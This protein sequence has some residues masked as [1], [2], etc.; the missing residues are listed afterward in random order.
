MKFL[1]RLRVLDHLIILYCS[2][3][4]KKVTDNNTLWKTIKPFL[5]DKIVSREKLTLI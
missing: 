3:L 5:S 1:T 2:D 4:E